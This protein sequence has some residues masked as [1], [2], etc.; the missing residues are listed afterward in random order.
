MILVIGAFD[1]FHR[2]HVRLLE[3]ARS[4]ACSLGT[5]WGVLTFFPHPGVFMGA[6]RSTLFTPRELELIR[7][8]LNVPYLLRISF[9]DRLRNL[10][11]R[12]FWRELRRMVDVEGIVVGKD[13]RFGHGGEG[14]VSLLEA[15]CREDG[16]S[17]GVEELLERDGAKLSSSSIRA[18]VEAGDVSGAAKDLGYPWFLWTD[19]LHG[20]GRGRRMGFPT[21]NLNIGGE[22]T[23]PAP[24]VYAVALI[25]GGRWRCGAL[26][27][28]RN[29]TFDDVR[30]LRSEVFVLDFEG[31]LY[32]EDLPVFF[33]E[34]LRPERHFPDA[35]RLTAQIASDVERCRTIYDGRME[36]EPTLFA[37]FFRHFT[38][39]GGQEEDCPRNWRMGEC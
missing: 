11:P 38:E 32:G 17:F 21:A 13:F 9:D 19:V 39:M 7:R 3:R 14:T 20:H 35:E 37:S 15:F 23:L 12:A 31:D 1:G 33:L 27:I 24:G 25:A 34:R 22:R 30:E 4:M 18:R 16:L 36:S 10:V 6:M 5:D 2:G 8:V 29:P 26:S 28:G